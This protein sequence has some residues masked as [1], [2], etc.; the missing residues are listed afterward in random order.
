MGIAHE[1]S[2]KDLDGRPV[3]VRTALFDSGSEV[4]ASDCGA[5]GG[6]QSWRVGA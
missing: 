1:L 2:L 6:G 3:E 5:A 4:G